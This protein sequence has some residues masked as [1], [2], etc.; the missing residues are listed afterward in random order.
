MEAVKGVETKMG[1]V[2]KRL[3]DDQTARKNADAEDTVRKRIAE[4]QS[5][6][7]AAGYN[8]DGVKKIME[9]DERRKHISYK[10][11]SKVFNTGRIEA[12]EVENLIEAANRVC[13]RAT[14]RVIQE[15]TMPG[16]SFPTR[17]TY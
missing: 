1:E 6:L 7:R 9:L 16:E 11:K 8:E 4:G 10:D 15:R 2:I 17:W 5:M 13:M 3:D 14:A 12:L